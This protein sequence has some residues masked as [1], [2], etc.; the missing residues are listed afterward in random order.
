MFALKFFDLALG[1]IA[2]CCNSPTATRTEY[3]SQLL[4]GQTFD[5]QLDSS[6]SKDARRFTARS[7]AAP[8][9]TDGSC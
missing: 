4:T 3:E 7:R 2:I 6:G 5:A 8:A 1:S 9:L